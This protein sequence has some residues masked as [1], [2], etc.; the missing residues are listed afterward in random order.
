MNFGF[1]DNLLTVNGVTK[2]EEVCDKEAYPS[3]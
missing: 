2:V 3:P 1:A